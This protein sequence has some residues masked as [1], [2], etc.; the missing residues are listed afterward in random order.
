MRGSVVFLEL[1]NGLPFMEGSWRN[2]LDSWEGAWTYPTTHPL[3]LAPLI[4]PRDYWRLW[5]SDTDPEI[6]TMLTVRSLIDR[7]KLIS[8]REQIRY[9]LMQRIQQFPRKIITPR[10]VKPAL[11]DAADLTE[12]GGIRSDKEAVMQLRKDMINVAQEAQAN[13][14]PL[15][16]W[17][18]SLLPSLIDLLRRHGMRLVF[19][20]VPQARIFDRAFATPMRIVDQSH[21]KLTAHRWGVP[22]LTFYFP[23]TNEDFPDLL[24]ISHKRED[25]F[26]RRLAEVWADY[27]AEQDRSK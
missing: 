23:V 24:H 13:Q 26:S 15:R 20:E 27:L 2:A 4:Q 8:V 11:D 25:E 1:A 5:S 12:R 10:T 21:F 14:K 6:I 19:F 16:A 9:N 18:Q 7:L 3:Q 22:I 17:D